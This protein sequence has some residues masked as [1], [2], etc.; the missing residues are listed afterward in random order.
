MLKELI[1]TVAEFLIKNPILLLFLVSAIGYAIGEIK[2]GSFRLGIVGVLLTGL[3]F[4]AFHPGFK[5]DEFEF[6]YRF[7]L[8]LFV[9]TVGLSNGPSFYMMLKKQ[10]LRDNLFT[11]GVIT[12]AG[13]IVVVV[14]KLF[15]LKASL[16]SGV[17]AGSLTNTPALAGVIEYMKVN[18]SKDLFTQLSS[19]PVIA[20]SVVYPFGVI[21][22]MIAILLLQKAFKVDYVKEAESLKIPGITSEKLL[23][24]TVEITKDLDSSIQ[25]I[26]EKNHLQV[27]LGRIKRTERLSLIIDETRVKQGDLITIIGNEE[28]IAKLTN[29]IGKTSEKSIQFEIKDI[30]FKNIVISSHKIAGTKLSDLKLSEK[31]GGIITRIKRGDVDLLANDDFVIQLGDSLRVVAPRDKM[32]KICKFFGDSYKAI[33]EVNFL[34]LGLGIAIGLLIGEI[35]VPLPGGTIFKLG[36]AGGPLI[37]GLVLGILGRTGKVVWQIPYNANLT[38]RQLGIILFLAGVGTRSGYAFITTLSSGI[39]G[40]KLLVAGM[41]VTFVTAIIALAFGY[42]VLKIPMSVLIGMVSGMQTQPALLAFSCEKTKNELPN[43]GYTSTYPMAMI[44]KIII[45]QIVFTILSVAVVN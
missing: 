33:S 42:K 10:G 2:F 23:S 24:Q 3:F 21:G 14:S 18:L 39:I 9:Y 15:F 43:I 11:L 36:L 7:G 27:V 30:E 26:I 16:S 41:I 5:L 8:V 1:N 32:E 31:F 17:F 20:Y 35:P 37:V 45:A 19:D 44:S 40:I 34:T 22:V 38:L 25:E 12:L 6:I 13:V 4:G 28:E 29:L